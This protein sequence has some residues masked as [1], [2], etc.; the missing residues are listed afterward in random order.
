[1]KKKYHLDFLFMKMGSTEKD[2]KRKER[3]YQET[4]SFEDRAETWRQADKQTSRQALL[5]TAAHVAKLMHPYANMERRTADK[6]NL[7]SSLF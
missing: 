3:I 6:G 7:Y 2:K 4:T 5:Q 1:M